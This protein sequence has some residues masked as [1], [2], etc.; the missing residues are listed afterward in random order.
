MELFSAGAGHFQEIAQFLSL[1]AKAVQPSNGDPLPGVK[2]L[3]EPLSQLELVS[4]GIDLAEYLIGEIANR[5]QH[6]LQ[7][8]YRYGLDLVE[9]KQHEKETHF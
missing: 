3:C 7:V 6:V 2:V 4:L 9:V 5:K 8:N 1:C